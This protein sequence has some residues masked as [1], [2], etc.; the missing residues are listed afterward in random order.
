[1]MKGSSGGSAISTTQLVSA[2]SVGLSARVSPAGAG[3]T[4]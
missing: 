2:G 1:V 3:V 4:A